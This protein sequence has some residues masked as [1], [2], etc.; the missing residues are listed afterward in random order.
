MMNSN[1]KGLTI[2][3]TAGVATYVADIVQYLI[4]MGAGDLPDKVD[5]AITGLT[6]AVVGYLIYKFLP[7]APTP[8]A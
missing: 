5:A 2:G 8:T 3:I 7:P 6:V 4:E 1:A